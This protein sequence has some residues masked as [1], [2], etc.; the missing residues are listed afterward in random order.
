MTLRVLA[1]ASGVLTAAR[2][3]E[4]WSVKWDFD[5]MLCLAKTENTS[6]SECGFRCNE[7]PRVGK[8]WLLMFTAAASLYVAAVK[9]LFRRSE[10]SL[11]YD[12]WTC[13]III[14]ML[15]W[16]DYVCLMRSDSYDEVMSDVRDGTLTYAYI[17]VTLPTRAWILIW[18]WGTRSYANRID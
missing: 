7:L 1:I 16:N 12:F 14:K 11:P 18:H 2:K 10:R 3:L 9:L 4:M 8:S 6:C 17:C 13:Y 15:C 5:L